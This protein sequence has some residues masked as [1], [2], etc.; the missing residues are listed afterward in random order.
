LDLGLGTIPDADYEYTYFT[1][2]KAGKLRDFFARLS[3]FLK[4]LN[5]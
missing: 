3:T 1:E 5:K 4:N 2:I